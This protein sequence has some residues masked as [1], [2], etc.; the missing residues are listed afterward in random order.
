[1]IKTL[2]CLIVVL[3]LALCDGDEWDFLSS[4]PT[5]TEYENIC[6]LQVQSESFKTKKTE[7]LFAFAGNGFNYEIGC[8]IN[9]PKMRPGDKYYIIDLIL[10]GPNTRVAK[11]STSVAFS[12]NKKDIF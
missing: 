12:F 4:S 2:I 10:Y 3:K 1:M 6:Q 11:V 7:V 8:H 9:D 5:N